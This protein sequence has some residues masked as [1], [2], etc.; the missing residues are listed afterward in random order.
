MKMDYQLCMI[1][2]APADPFRLMGNNVQKS[3]HWPE[4]RLQK[5]TQRGIGESL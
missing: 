2:R 4:V 1:V 3:Q 5:D